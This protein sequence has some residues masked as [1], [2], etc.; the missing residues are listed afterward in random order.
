MRTKLLSFIL[1]TVLFSGIANAQTKTWD[2]GNNSGGFWPVTASGVGTIGA[3]TSAV[4][5]NLGL[6]SND[7]ANSAIA[8]FG[9]VTVSTGTFTDGYT[10]PNRFQMNGGGGG[11]TGNLLPTQR[12]LFLN[13]S[14]A[15]T[16]TVWFKTGSN[17]AVRTVMVTNG[18]TLLGSGTS[19]SGANADTVIF[20]ATVTAAQAAAGRI[21]IYG[22]TT[23]NN[24]YKIT[25]T[26][27]T[28]N[29]QP[30][31]N[32]AFQGESPVAVFSNGNQISVANVL[33]STDVKVYSMTGA[34]VKSLNTDTDT[35]FELLSAGVY[36][37]NVTSAEGQKAVKVS[38][39]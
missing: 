18:T 28:V 3:G 36:I 10:G 33:S 38:I 25:V 9:A 4:I 26:G 31:A 11:T 5:D 32:D 2:F 29:T 15:C 22:D 27:A 21:Y 17:G 30:L 37:V 19:N 13:V 20:T 23:A 34:L 6:F 8:N 39:K 16:I 35:S 24:L 14:G 1:T 7:P 12:Y